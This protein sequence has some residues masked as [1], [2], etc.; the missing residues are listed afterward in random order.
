MTPT[1]KLFILALRFAFPETGISRACALEYRA[2]RLKTGLQFT[3]GAGIRLRLAASWFSKKGDP[4]VFTLNPAED[5]P[6]YLH[7]SDDYA[8]VIGGCSSQ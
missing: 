4:H 5:V 1:T 3:A 8:R 7:S 6:L 2:D